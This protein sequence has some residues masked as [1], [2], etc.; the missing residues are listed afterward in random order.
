MN[1]TPEQAMQAWLDKKP[2][3]YRPIGLKQWVN[4]HSTFNLCQLIVSK[5]VAEFR[6]KSPTIR[7]GDD[8]VPEP[9]REELEISAPYWHVNFSYS[10]YVSRR[11]QWTQHAVDYARLSNGVIHL[12]QEAAQIHAD[13]LIKLN[14]QKPN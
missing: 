2:L 4:V 7:I 3:Q 13:A 9:V 14:N 1:L 11:E 10:G 12:T 6:L 8:D 5:D